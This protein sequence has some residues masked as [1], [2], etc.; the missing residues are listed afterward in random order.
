MKLIITI[1]YGLVE[2]WK[3]NSMAPPFSHPWPLCEH[4]ESAR[5]HTTPTVHP[6]T[7]SWP[8]SLSS[9]LQLQHHYPGPGHYLW[10][11]GKLISHPH[12]SKT[13]IR[14]PTPPLGARYLF[15]HWVR[16]HS[17]KTT[18]SAGSSA[19]PFPPHHGPQWGRRGNPNGC[20]NGLS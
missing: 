17:E 13:K 9:C 12:A 16:L 10:P 19:S 15:L 18:V 8:F 7:K 3:W 11:W 4:P 6:A 14:G 20:L 1:S 2:N 5:R